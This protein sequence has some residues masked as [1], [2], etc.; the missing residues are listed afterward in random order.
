[1]NAR[2]VFVSTMSLEGS[3]RAQRTSNRGRAGASDQMPLNEKNASI[4]QSYFVHYRATV[5]IC[6]S[7]IL[8]AQTMST[9]LTSK[10]Q[11]TIPKHIRDALLLQPG[12]SVEFTVNG[13]GQVVVQ[14]A[15]K[16]ARKKPIDRFEAARGKA[17]IKWRTDDL[18]KLLRDES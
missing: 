14:P 15:A 6:W 16:P 11:V 7:V 12:G 4:K 5:T 8:K 3:V 10:G 18:M 13:A 1:M 17:T 2:H 9:T